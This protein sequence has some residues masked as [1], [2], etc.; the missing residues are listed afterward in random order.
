MTTFDVSVLRLWTDLFFE[1]ILIVWITLEAMLTYIV[2]RLIAIMI[3][4]TV[5]ANKMLLFI[6][7]IIGFYKIHLN[8][9]SWIKSPPPP[10]LPPNTSKNMHFFFVSSFFMRRNELRKLSDI[11]RFA[12]ATINILFL[13]YLTSDNQLPFTTIVQ[14][15][16]AQTVHRRKPNE[17][18]A[19]IL[20]RCVR[21]FYAILNKLLLRGHTPSW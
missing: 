14:I 16:K 17:I 6:V 5:A 20:W 19:N 7:F 1:M 4:I 8:R 2:W 15:A 18:V 11:N 3:W 10:L 21:N 12:F 13:M 9:R